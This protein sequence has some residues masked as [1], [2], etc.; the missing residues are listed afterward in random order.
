[1]KPF[2]D[3][4][5]AGGLLF[6]GAMG[7]MLYQ[8]GVFLNRC[9]EYVSVEQ[10]ETVRAI[11]EEYVQAGAKVLTANTFGANRMKLER[12]GLSDDIVAINQT[13]VRLAREASGGRAYV[14]GSV[15]PTGVQ[16]NELAGPEGQR[17]TAALR[18][19]MELLIGAG[20]DLLCLETF[21]LVSELE[22]AIQLAK[23]LCSLPVVALCKFN[24][25]QTTRRGLAPEVVAKRLIA[26]G[27]DVVGANCGGGPDHLFRVSTAMVG[28]GRPVVAM[29]NAGL[30]EDIEGRT[31]YVANPEYFGVFARRL[32]KGGVHITGGCC[33]TTPDHIR[34]MANAA[35]MVT[36]CGEDSRI[37]AGNDI[38]VYD[39]PSSSL[40]ARSELGRKLAAGEFITSVELNPPDGLSL[41]KK[42]KAAEAL[43][44]F[45]VTTINIADGPRASMRMSN[46]SMAVTVAEA[47][48]LEPLVHVCCRDRN[49]LG[50]QSHILGMH[51]LGVRN[52]VVITGDP[53]KMG[54]FP[55]ATG[56]YDVN[57]IG[58]LNLISGFNH[59]LDPSGKELV[60]ATNFVCATGA[61]P[62]ALDY[63]RE[64]KRLDMKFSAGA[65]L[66]MTQPVYDPFKV[67]KFLEDAERIGIPVMLGLCP[68]ASYRNAKF[69][70]DN[71]PGMQVPEFILNRM[72]KADEDGRGQDE[73]IAIAR[74][75]LA[76]T[77]GQI[78]GAY[79]MPPFGRYRAAMKVL[80]GYVAVENSDANVTID[81]LEKSAIGS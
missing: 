10:P 6:D 47:T 16:L 59:G 27:A 52:L 67:E 1:M 13:S 39:G 72:A 30:P 38:K 17:A 29:A 44:A 5:N 19:Q 22:L 25:G 51:V 40:A 23:D 28:L 75:T 69:L 58:L 71:V 35:R 56:V 20:V 53:P 3:M 45:G 43:K 15:G 18:E 65:H 66:V 50:L 55:H 33:G 32:F 34:R 2:L 37:E 63:G 60:Q 7:T 62:A 76:A 24:A 78:Q 14:A 74:E 12:H 26:A 9:F 46:V 31:I 70:N 79:I 81:P 73:G 36:A 42:I 4:A 80:E 11:H 57:S 41:D 48:G 21:D 54:P 77:R 61:E 49:Y 8:R 64:I 68:L